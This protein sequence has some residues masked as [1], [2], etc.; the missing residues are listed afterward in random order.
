MLFRSVTGHTPPDERAAALRALRDA[1]VNVLFTVDVFNEGLDVPDVDTV[2]FLR[3]TESSTIFMQQLGRGLRRTTN[4]AVLTVLDFVGYH[5]KEFSFARK[6]GALTGLHGKQLEKAVREE[7]PFLPSGCQVRLDQQTQQVV[8]DNLR[9]QLS[10]RWNQIVAHL[11]ATKDDSLP[12]FLDTS[13]LELSDVLRS[14]EHTSEL[15]SH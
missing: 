4:K 2:L 11:R 14:E 6:F 13:G 3:P 1:D 8:L 9:S 15:Q 5:R 12:A 10:S 7:F